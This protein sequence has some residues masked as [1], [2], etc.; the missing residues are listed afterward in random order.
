MRPRSGYLRK[1]AGGAQ[2]NPRT[3]IHAPS[4]RHVV[5]PQASY[6]VSFV[7]RDAVFL[8]QSPIFIE[9]RF[10]AVMFGLTFDIFD[11][12]VLSG[13]RCRERA[14]SVLPAFKPAER[15][16]LL[17]PAT[18]ARFRLL[19]IIGQRHACRNRGQDMNVVVDASD[20]IQVAIEILVDSPDT[21][22]KILSMAVGQRA[23]A[24]LGRENDVKRQLVVGIWDGEP[25]GNVLLAGWRCRSSLHMRA[26]S[27]SAD[28]ETGRRWFG[29]DGGLQGRPRGRGVDCSPDSFAV[30]S[31]QDTASEAEPRATERRNACNSASVFSLKTPGKSR[32]LPKSRIR[33]AARFST[34]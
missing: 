20:A 13:K 8:G 25:R 28:L 1:A 30:R 2:R 10:R 4:V 23:L 3:R 9:Q 22:I 24:I 17:E 31:C 15:Y 12:R 18:T 5:A 7:E 16:L 26:N 6:Q 19:H 21:A 33:P 11:E 32:C 29:S 14:V 27:A 34:W